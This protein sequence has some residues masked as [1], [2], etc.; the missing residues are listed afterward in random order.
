MATM[1]KSSGMRYASQSR[2][3]ISFPTGDVATASTVRFVVNNVY[4]QQELFGPSA[5][6]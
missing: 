1:G 6:G 3:W 4:H 5:S 2:F